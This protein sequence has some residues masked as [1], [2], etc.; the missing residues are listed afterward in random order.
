MCRKYQLFV[1]RIA[2]VLHVVDHDPC[3]LAP[4][5]FSLRGRGQGSGARW[6]DGM[7]IER[8]AAFIAYVVRNDPGFLASTM[9]E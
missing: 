2:T 9:I 3:R 7:S 5:G 6:Q 4:L 8:E 1:C